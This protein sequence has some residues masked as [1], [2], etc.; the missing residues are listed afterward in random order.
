MWG[1]AR[2]RVR[3]NIQWWSIR[4]VEELRR[5]AGHRVGIQVLVLLGLVVGERVLLG[6]EAHVAAPVYGK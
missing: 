5:G 4:I 2:V 6:L 3:A 1:S